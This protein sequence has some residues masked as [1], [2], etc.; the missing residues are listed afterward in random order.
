MKRL[1]R[2][3]STCSDLYWPIW[4][5]DFKS[6]CPIDFSLLGSI[7]SNR[8]INVAART[9]QLENASRD[10]HDGLKR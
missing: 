9:P 7:N 10:Q 3:Y 6:A 8:N 4:P 2:I 1:H 5:T